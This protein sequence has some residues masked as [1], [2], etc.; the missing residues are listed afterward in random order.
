MRYGTRVTDARSR[1]LLAAILAAFAFLHFH[2]MG[3]LSW[4]WDEGTDLAIVNC[5][6]SSGNPFACTDDI[7]QTRFPFYLHAIA[8]K[9]FSGEWPHFLI[10]FAFSALTLLAVYAYARREYG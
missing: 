4:T 7:S 10:S 2:R 9:M 3:E 1:W 8:G 6:E 5:L